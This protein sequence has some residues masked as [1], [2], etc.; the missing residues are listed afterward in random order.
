MKKLT[1][2]MFLLLGVMGMA[3]KIDSC[4]IISKGIYDDGVKYVNCISNQTGNHFNFKHVGYSV[5]SY[6]EKGYSY[7][8]FFEGT[9]YSDLYITKI[10]D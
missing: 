10:E 2:L 6:L 5:F 4:Q 9:G 1:V 3:R 8:I 7:K